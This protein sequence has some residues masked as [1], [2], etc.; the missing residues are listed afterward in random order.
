MIDVSH[1]RK[2]LWMLLVIFMSTNS[3]FSL[4]IILKS[5]DVQ[6]ELILF[7]VF[8]LAS[9]FVSALSYIRST[10]TKSLDKIGLFIWITQTVFN[11]F[12]III[13]SYWINSTIKGTAKVETKLLG[14]L[15]TAF[16]ICFA[17]SL[18]LKTIA[19][20]VT[21]QYLITRQIDLSKN[22]DNE[23]GST[24]CSAN[25]TFSDKENASISSKIVK[26]KDSAQTL[27]PDEINIKNIKNEHRRKLNVQ[28]AECVNMG[29]TYFVEDSSEMTTQHL[30]F[31]NL[32]MPNLS[33]AGGKSI[34]PHFFEKEFIPSTPILDTADVSQIKDLDSTQFF[35]KY[36]SFHIDHRNVPKT[37]TS[38]VDYDHFYEDCVDSK[39]IMS[40]N[41]SE[42]P[43]QDMIPETP[44]DTLNKKKLTTKF[45]ETTV[46]PISAHLDKVST[47]NVFLEELSR[48]IRENDLYKL[49]HEESIEHLRSNSVKQVRKSFSK[50]LKDSLSST[51]LNLNYNR[52]NNFHTK[53]N[54]LSALNIR[55][56]KLQSPLKKVRNLKDLTDKNH[57]KEFLQQ[58]NFDMNLVNNIRTSPKKKTSS[59]SLN[60]KVKNSLTRSSSTRNEWLGSKEEVYTH[61]G[62]STQISEEFSHP[63][64]KGIPKDIFPNLFKPRNFSNNTDKSTTSSNSLPSGY[65]GQYDK[66]K[67]QAFKKVADRDCHA[68]IDLSNISQISTSTVPQISC[69]PINVLEQDST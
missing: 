10:S 36:Q 22:L 8:E 1:F 62:N 7:V 6:V 16:C 43:V 61:S 42:A 24:T 21:L 27:V 45:P 4:A 38:D 60:S 40:L 28:L 37:K 49:R 18:I 25:C 53:S 46:S 26:L 64:V 47:N 63:H 56:S 52:Q 51:T 5:T 31:H 44:H 19:G 13:W 32:S 65:Y 33:G 59:W 30:L 11:T 55:K 34:I 48:E 3:A 54:S 68:Q 58:L 66:E 39:K 57:D 12:T 50:T 17:L 29:E 69:A 15:Q 14:R 67:W 35:S 2:L 20:L 41:I 23:T 9:L